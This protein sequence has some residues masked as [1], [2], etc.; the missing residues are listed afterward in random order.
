MNIIEIRKQ[1][2][3]LNEILATNVAE[4]VKKAEINEIIRETKPNHIIYKVRGVEF[5]QVDN[6]SGYDR[7]VTYSIFINGVEFFPY[8]SE[9]LF[10]ELHEAYQNITQIKE[11]QETI[12]FIGKVI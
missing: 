3:D 5:H 4:L 12:I 10:D 2:K 8:N 6:S 7:H 11:L 9:K 1:K